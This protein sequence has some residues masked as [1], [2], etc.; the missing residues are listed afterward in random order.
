LI[1][2][3]AFVALLTLAAAQAA[4]AAEAIAPGGVYG[5]D[6]GCAAVASG[7]YPD[8]DDW[9]V[10][11]GKYMRQHESVC[12]FVQKLPDQYG[13][14]FVNAICSGEGDTWP[15]SF[16]IST[17]EDEGDVR[18]S[19]TNNNPWD[20]HACDGLTDTAADKLFGE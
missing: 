6:D 9:L 4:L 8:S 16:V 20:V 2:R 19:D 14:L 7:Q 15:T 10:L 3:A 11:T 5:T 17:G 18:I 1:H 12:N 13:S